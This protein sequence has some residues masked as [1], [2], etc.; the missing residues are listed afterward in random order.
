[1]LVLGRFLCDPMVDMAFK[2]AISFSP[3]VWSVV[4]F[5]RKR[6]MRRELKQ[7]AILQS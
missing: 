3:Q 1:M 5:D 4:Q 2:L 6:Q 7:H